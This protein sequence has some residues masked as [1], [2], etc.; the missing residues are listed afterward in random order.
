MASTAPSS[1]LPLAEAMRTHPHR[2][3]QAGHGTL[4][5]TAVLAHILTS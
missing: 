1:A 3:E 4:D 2:A 5:Y